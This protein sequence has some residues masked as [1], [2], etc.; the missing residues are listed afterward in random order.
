MANNPNEYAGRY[1]CDNIISQEGYIGLLYLG[2]PRCF[3]LIRDAA[4]FEY[5]EYDEWKANIAEINWLDPADIQRYTDEEKEDVIIKLWN[6]S[7]EYDEKN[8]ELYYS[9]LEDEDE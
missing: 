5:S 2:F 8:E 1:W 9:A 3:I 6:F 4:R 7:V